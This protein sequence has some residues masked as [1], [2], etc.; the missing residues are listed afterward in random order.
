MRP[1]TRRSTLALPVAGWAWGLVPV[2]TRSS[3]TNRQS[4][5]CSF[6]NRFWTMSAPPYRISCRANPWTGLTE[7][8][9]FESCRRGTETSR[10][11]LWLRGPERLALESRART[12]SSQAVAVKAIC[13][14]ARLVGGGG[15]APQHLTTSRASEIGSDSHLPVEILDRQP[16]IEAE[17]CG[18]WNAV[19]VTT[20]TSPWN[21]RERAGRRS[22]PF[23]E[24]S[25]TG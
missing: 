12:Y 18:P 11:L 7:L 20:Q 2:G 5:P 23:T 16:E 1:I 6:E 10:C 3:A 13:R 24:I 21:Y 9:C 14:V 4:N 19:A 17:R 15:G 8:W 22:I 25:I